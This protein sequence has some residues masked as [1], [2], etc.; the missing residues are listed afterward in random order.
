MERRR[1]TRDDA[2]HAIV[3]LPHWLMLAGALLV[4]AGCLKLA[5][6]RRIVEAALKNRQKRFVLDGEAVVLGLDGISDFNALHSRKH[7]E[8][9]Q[10]CAFDIL[11]DGDDDLRKIPLSMR[12]ASLDRLL[13]RRPEGIFVNP[14]ERGEIGPDLFWAAC[15]MGLEGLVSKRRDRPYQAG[16]SKHWIKVK[17]RSHPA[18]QRGSNL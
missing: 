15:Q 7:D 9:V 11:V 4:I 12:K 6:S 5:I 10:I 3:G 2:P 1:F 13:A 17:N 18:M 16:R 8:E 14:F